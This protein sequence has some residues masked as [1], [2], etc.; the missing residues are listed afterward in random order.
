M[1][2]TKESKMGKMIKSVDLFGESPGFL[3]NGSAT[4]GT[5]LGALLSLG[6]IVITLSYGIR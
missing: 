6:V 2:I 1:S 4:K 5:F 3:I